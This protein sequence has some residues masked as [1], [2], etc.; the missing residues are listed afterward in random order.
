V[1]KYPGFIG[2]GYTSQSRIADVERTVNL[3]PEKIESGVGKADWVLYPGPGFEEVVEL[4]DSPVRGLYSLNGRTFAVAGTHLYE[5]APD[6]TVTERGDG[7]NDLDGTP[8][9]MCGNGDGGHQLFITS[10]SKGYIFDT[11]DS[12]FSMVLDGASQGGFIDGFFLALDPQSSTLKISELEDG[13][14][15][16]ATQVAQR[17]AGADRWCGMICSHKEI[18]LFGSLTTEVWYNDGAAPFPFAPNPSVFI[19]FGILAPYSVAILDNAPI[20]LGQSAD[21]VGVVYRANGYTPQR[22][23]NHALE[24]RLSTF[25]TLLDAHA[26]TYQDQGHAF[27][28]LTFPTAQETWVYDAA[29]GAWHERGS[30]DGSRFIGSPVWQHTYAYGKHLVGGR[31]TGRIY[32]Q[33][34]PRKSGDA[35]SFTDDANEL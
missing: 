23:S 25:E 35:W 26:W 7:I 27:Y 31:V 30:W 24:Y 9:T 29:T 19:N 8:A 32:E 17:N 16:D 22:V 15:W 33:A 4:D 13:T 12:S 21:G 2:P 5:I 34:I 11:E 6:W 14:T 3:Y 10:G 20:W 18:W 1:A 28:V